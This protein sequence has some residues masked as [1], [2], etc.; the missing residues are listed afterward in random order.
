MAGPPGP[1]KGRPEDKLHVSAIHVEQ[2][3]SAGQCTRPSVTRPTSHSGPTW[4]AGT[5]AG[6]DGLAMCISSRVSGDDGSYFPSSIQVEVAAA[7]SAPFW[8]M[9]D[10]R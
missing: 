2:A 4:M 5:E 9:R 6:H 3:T 7:T 10:S 1:A 8:V